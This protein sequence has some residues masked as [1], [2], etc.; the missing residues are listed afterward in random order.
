MDVDNLVADDEAKSFQRRPWIRQRLEATLIGGS[1]SNSG[2]GGS[3]SFLGAATRQAA[4]MSVAS[5][6][7]SV[8]L[9][10]GNMT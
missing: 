6:V 5:N 4:A 1:G 9:A 7:A 3:S 2:G 10:R 8:G